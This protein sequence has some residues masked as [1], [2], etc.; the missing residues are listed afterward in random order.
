MG[1]Y[2]MLRYFARAV[3]LSPLV[4]IAVGLIVTY[5]PGVADF[6]SDVFWNY[7]GEKNTIFSLASNIIQGG[8][9]YSYFSW[10]NYWG[11]FLAL[12]FGA[13]GESAI[14]A[15]CIFAVKSSRVRFTR[16]AKGIID[17]SAWLLTLIGVLLGIFVCGLKGML[18]ASG[19]A[20]LTLVVCLGCYLF[21]IRLMFRGFTYNRNSTYSNRRA[22]FIIEMLLGIVGNMF[23][24]FCAVFFI[25][26]WFEGPRLM[27]AGASVVV[28][29][30]WMGLSAALLYLKILVMKMLAP[31]AV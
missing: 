29:F 2:K 30:A 11:G 21:G 14:I 3:L 18:A 8:M 6:L 20:I 9:S 12:L 26:G 7:L 5:L 25:T 27:R 19:Q 1:I 4:L 28:W 13:L 15:C 17:G 31:Q 24:A 22:G 16:K 10:D 23:D